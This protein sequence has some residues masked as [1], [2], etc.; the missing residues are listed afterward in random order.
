MQT[1]PSSAPSEEA[2]EGVVVGL[3]RYPVKSMMGE[4]LNAAD[5]TERGLIGRDRVLQRLI[6]RVRRVTSA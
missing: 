5:V 6:A 3:W 2:E 1:E 4:D